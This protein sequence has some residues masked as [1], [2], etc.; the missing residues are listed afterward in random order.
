MVS[1]WIDEML[2]SYHPIQQLIIDNGI[3]SSQVMKI[4]NKST[5]YSNR[6][7]MET[8]TIDDVLKML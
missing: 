6:E 2:M 1:Q 4:L 7:L 3:T 8:M 5:H